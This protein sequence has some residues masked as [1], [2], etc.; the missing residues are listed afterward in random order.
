MRKLFLAV[1]IGLSLCCM[2]ALVGGVI[3]VDRLGGLNYLIFKIREGDDATGTREGREEMFA[4]V[5]RE[6]PD[7]IVF[8][9]DSI[10]QMVEWSEALGNPDALNRGIGGDRSGSLLARV[11][12]VVSIRPRQVFVMIGVNDIP[13]GSVSEIVDNVVAISSTIA[14]RSPETEVIVMSILPVNNGIRE[15]RR[16]NAKIMEVNERLAEDVQQTGA[17][18][19]DLWGEFVD[20]NGNLDSRFSYD[21]LHL[22]GAGIAHLISQIEPHVES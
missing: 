16:N 1:L 2:A 9:G 7:A 17:V 4:M 8:A 18:W 13:T 14:S 15:T 6:R 11:D 3:V 20:Q 5:S 12:D 21:G 22:N 10:T 19:L